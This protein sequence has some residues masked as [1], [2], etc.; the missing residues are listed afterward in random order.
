MYQALKKYKKTPDDDLALQLNEQFD[1][2]CEPVINY[3][4][5][6][7]V[8]EKLRENKDQ[9]LVV[10]L[11]PN[12]SLHNN[13]SESDI[14]E[15][16]KRRKISAGTRS[17]NGRLARDT[18]LSLKKTCRKLEISFWEYLQDRLQNLNNIPPLSEIMTQKYQL[19]LG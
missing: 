4:S 13:D 17:E 15:Y 9:L 6:N 10:L 8:L 5:L 2:L 7:Q 12:S 1:T 16:V 18:F 14:R 19:S 11:R 3:S